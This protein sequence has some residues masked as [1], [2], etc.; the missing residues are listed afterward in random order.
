MIV[1][2]CVY[3]YIHSQRVWWGLMVTWKGET[4]IGIS[5][6][7]NILFCQ[8]LVFCCLN[9][10][11]KFSVACCIYVL[12]CFLCIKCVSDT[13]TIYLF[14]SVCPR[15]AYDWCLF[16]FHP[17]FMID[18]HYYVIISFLFINYIK[19]CWILKYPTYL[20]TNCVPYLYWNTWIYYSTA[21]IFS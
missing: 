14:Y 3:K 4:R 15:S 19:Q 5:Y 12:H 18:V 13:T 10:V 11:Q 8:K 16:D 6:H 9:L 21:I 1:D 7:L 17:L 2:L 20:T